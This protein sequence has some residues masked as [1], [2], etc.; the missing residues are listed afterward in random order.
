MKPKVL[1]IDDDVQQL[2]MFSARLG[3]YFDIAKLSN[4]LNCIDFLKANKVDAIVSDLHMPIIN[5]IKFYELLQKNDI[6]GIPFFFLSNDISP[7]SKVTGL[8]MGAFDYLSHTMTPDEIYFRINNRI[9]ESNLKFKNITINL[10]NFTATSGQRL[11]DLTQI[12][13]KILL[14][15]VKKQGQL[16]TRD[17]LKEFIWPNLS[18]LD[19]TINS[20]LTNL[21]MKIE[22]DNFKIISIKGKGMVLSCNDDNPM[23]T[24]EI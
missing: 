7:E 1:F 14:L 8:K 10:Q 2:E 17:E 15:L 21:R 23:A 18:V 9:Q 13:F 5:G 12:E 11:L 24:C 22:K 3:Q 20:H 6:I 4:P 16:V 19:K